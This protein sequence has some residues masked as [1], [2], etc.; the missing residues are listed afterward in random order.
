MCSLPE[1]QSSGSIRAV[2]AA[3]WL[4]LLN[5]V[6]GLSWWGLFLATRRVS[7]P[8]TLPLY[9]DCSLHF[10]LVSPSCSPQTPR[11]S[12]MEGCVKLT[13]GSQT[14]GLFLCSQASRVVQFQTIGSLLRWCQ[15]PAQEVSYTEDKVEF[16]SLSA[17]GTTASLIQKLVWG[18]WVLGAFPKGLLVSP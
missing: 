16:L 3:Q 12:V 13:S 18:L 6:W 2:T 11:L 14:C 15:V 8:C 7:L 4:Y 9:R 5:W 1:L 17:R 10:W